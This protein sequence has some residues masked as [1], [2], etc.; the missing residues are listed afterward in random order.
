MILILSP[1][2]RRFGRT[3]KTRFSWLWPLAAKLHHV[4]I[5]TRVNVLNERNRFSKSQSG[6]TATNVTVDLDSVNKFSGTMVNSLWSGHSDS[7]CNKIDGSL[8]QRLWYKS[9]DESSSRDQKSAEFWSDSSYLHRITLVTCWISDTKFA[10]NVDC[11]NESQKQK[12]S[13]QY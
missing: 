12:R 5:I 3:E 10:I 4:G 13:A 6:G 9:C 8:H 2:V 11:F 7:D 1:G